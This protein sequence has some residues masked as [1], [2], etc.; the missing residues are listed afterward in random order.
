M[1][2]LG[3]IEFQR[4]EAAGRIRRLWVDLRFPQFSR[5]RVNVFQSLPAFHKWSD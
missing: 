3:E 5:H 4:S 1:L 2:S